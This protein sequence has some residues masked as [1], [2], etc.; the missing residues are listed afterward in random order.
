L[1]KVHEL[2][3]LVIVLMIALLLT[4]AYAAQLDISDGAI[5]QFFSSPFQYDYTTIVDDASLRKFINAFDYQLAMIEYRQRREFTAG[6][7][8][9]VISKRFKNSLEERYRELM[10]DGFIFKKLNEWADTTG[11]SVNRAFIKLYLSRRDRL[12]VDPSA[13][14][15]AGELA[16]RIADRLY[17]FQYEVD[18]K[19]YRAGDAARIV[20]SGNDMT[21]ARKLDRL[22]N[23]SV[24]VLAGDAANLYMIYKKLGQQ[25]GYRTSLDYNLSRLSF[26]KP[27]WLKIADNLKKATESEYQQCLQFLK[28]EAGQEQLALFEIERRI[29]DGAV[30]PDSSFTVEKIDAAVRLLLAGLGLSDLTEKLTIRVD[31]SGYP[32]LA[33]RLCPPY[34]NLLLKNNQGGFGNYRRQTAELGRALPWV[35]ADSSL[36]YM[37]RDY[38]DG[39]EE[40]LTGLFEGLALDPEFLADNFNIDADDL[41]RFDAHQRWQTIYNLRRTLLYFYFDYLLSDENAPDPMKLYLSLESSLLGTGVSSYQW[42]EALITGGLETFPEKLAHAFS[43]IKTSEIL[44]NRYGENFKSHP[45]AGRFLIDNFCLPG[46]LQTIEDFITD[47]APS[48]LSVE[49]IK[50]QMRLR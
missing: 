25:R 23:D 27:E 20:F 38:P 36:P 15:Q 39:S 24:A 6:P 43:R 31:S 16:Q 12:M 41:K 28:I 40:M 45:A 2:S 50:R 26:R 10:R 44:F 11:D 9:T 3:I 7:N 8:D 33:I 37:M 42:I 35:Y 32:A 13:L 5:E 21:L 18:D 4:S 30:L 17:T 47:Y 29:T 19:K 14:R 48:R 49:D 1:S 34:D 46:R 22:V